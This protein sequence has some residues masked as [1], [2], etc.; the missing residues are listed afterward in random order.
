MTLINYR[1]LRNPICLY[2]KFIFFGQ[3]AFRDF[4]KDSRILPLIE[5]YI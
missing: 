3:K 4:V 5:K 1:E 2:D